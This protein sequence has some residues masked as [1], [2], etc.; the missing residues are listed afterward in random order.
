MEL[1]SNYV[2]LDV[3]G[4]DSDDTTIDVSNSE[5]VIVINTQR[6]YLDNTPFEEDET[7][8]FIEDS[9]PAAHSATV[10]G[11]ARLSKAAI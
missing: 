6:E 11:S 3:F 1:L 7:I 5:P 4:S 2:I 10:L 8:S 9:L